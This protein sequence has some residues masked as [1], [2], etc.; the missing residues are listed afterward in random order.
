MVSQAGKRLLSDDDDA[1]GVDPEDVQD[2][3]DDDTGLAAREHD[4]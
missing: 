1:F 2:R 4:G 3:I